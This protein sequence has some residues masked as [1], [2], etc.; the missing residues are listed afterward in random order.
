MNQDE[1]KQY[2]FIAD[3]S[4]VANRIGNE[5]VMSQKKLLKINK[6]MHRIVLFKTFAAFLCKNNQFV[7]NEEGKSKVIKL[8]KTQKIFTENR[9]LILLSH[10]LK[11]ITLTHC[12]TFCF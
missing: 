3:R 9:T 1:S 10:V 8:N 7:I 12:T 5:E 4:K 11:S 6:N 2:N